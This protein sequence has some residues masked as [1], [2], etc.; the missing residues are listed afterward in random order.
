[1]E[2]TSDKPSGTWVY[3]S[4]SRSDSSEVWKVKTPQY[5][6]WSSDKLLQ[7]KKEITSHREEMLVWQKH[8]ASLKDYEAARFFAN[9]ASDALK[10]YRGLCLILGNVLCDPPGDSPWKPEWDW[11]VE[12][13]PW[14]ERAEDCTL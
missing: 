9:E 7:K 3:R 8:F 2:K 6:S 10:E 14:I 4:Q 12:L 13:S 5:L 1:M 11:P